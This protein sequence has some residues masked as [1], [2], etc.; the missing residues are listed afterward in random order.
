VL[1]PVTILVVLVSIAAANRGDAAAHAGEL[2]HEGAH[3]AEAEAAP[4]GKLPFLPGREPSV[5]EI[6][7]LG[8]V[9]FT[10]VMGGLLGFS[11]FGQMG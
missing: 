10:L 8:A 4:S 3:T 2:S 5:L 1:L 6:L 11:I 7:I 9:L